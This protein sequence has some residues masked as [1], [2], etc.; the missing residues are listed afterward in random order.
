MSKENVENSKN[1]KKD[2]AQ[3]SI[4][5]T[6]LETQ[7]SGQ[8][9][10]TIS[11]STFMT[12][13]LV[14]GRVTS[15][16]KV[17]SN[18]ISKK[19][20]ELQLYTHDNE[21]IFTADGT[22]K[23][24]SHRENLVQ[25]FEERTITTSQESF[26]EN[27]VSKISQDFKKSSVKKI[28]TP[29]QRLACTKKQIDNTRITSNCNKDN[30]KK[31]TIKISLVPA[32]N[33]LMNDQN[34]NISP[35]QINFVAKDLDDIDDDFYSDDTS[36]FASNSGKSVNNPNDLS[37]KNGCS[38]SPISRI[39]AKHPNVNMYNIKENILAKSI[40]EDPI[41]DDFYD[42][43]GDDF[44]DSI[45]ES[46]FLIKEVE[47]SIENISKRKSLSSSISDQSTD[48]KKPHLEIKNYPIEDDFY[49]DDVDFNF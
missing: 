22:F 39:Q 13:L 29:F 2:E 34:K 23:K 8:I 41:K 49:D 48:I 6:D 21:E 15:T 30:L 38:V 14:S 31:E 12:G 11:Q 37:Q 35:Q 45:N 4:S 5:S 43:S 36:G 26:K 44:F 42:D 33:I 20:T 27:C 17:A 1:E 19:P 7:F 28:C 32:T 25:S 16:P 46:E 10:D 3:R 24:P 9:I 18:N 40:K 47:E